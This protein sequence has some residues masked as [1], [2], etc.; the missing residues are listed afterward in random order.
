MEKSG[1]KTWKHLPE[2]TGK[3]SG[4]NHVKDLVSFDCALISIRQKTFRHLLS[5][6]PKYIENRNYI[7]YYIW[8]QKKIAIYTEQAHEDCLASLKLETMIIF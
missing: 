2:I 8:T 6:L 5:F 1:K 4:I 3:H 7:L